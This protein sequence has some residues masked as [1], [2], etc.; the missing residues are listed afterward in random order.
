MRHSNIVVNVIGKQYETFNFKFKDVNV[1]GARRIARIAREEGV[2]RLI[3][4]SAVN[5]KENPDVSAQ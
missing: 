1:D 4:I 3:H 2:D 5:A